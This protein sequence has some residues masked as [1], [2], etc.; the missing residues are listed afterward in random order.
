MA[1][2]FSRRTVSFWVRARAYD[3]GP[4]PNARSSV[5]YASRAAPPTPPNGN[6]NIFA[7]TEPSKFGIKFNLNAGPP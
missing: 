6:V 2:A 1:Q 4:R 7:L 5:L 3:I